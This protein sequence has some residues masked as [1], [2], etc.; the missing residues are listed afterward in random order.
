MKRQ[1]PAGGRN[2][3]DLD[4]RVA[5]AKLGRDLCLPSPAAAAWRRR[6]VGFE[7]Q[8]AAAGE[9][10]AEVD[11]RAAA[12]RP[13]SAGDLGPS[14]IRLGN[15]EQDAEPAMTSE[16]DQTFQR[17]KIEHQSLA[18]LAGL[19]SDTWLSVDLTTR[20]LTP[21][22]ELDLDLVVGDLGDLADDAAAGDDLVALLDRRDRRLMLLHP[23]LLRADH[24]ELED[25]E[26]QEPA[27]AI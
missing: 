7:Q 20:T 2:V 8:L 19:A 10:E 6:R 5:A 17:G 22:R 23:L 26:D 13:A 9:V 1:P 18:G 21:W 3:A 4:P 11:L 27:A 16:T 15:G 25:H 24:Q 14:A 12:A